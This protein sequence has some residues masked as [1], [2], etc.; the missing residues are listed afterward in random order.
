MKDAI[1]RIVVRKLEMKKLIYKSLLRELPPSDHPLL[2]WKQANLPKRAS[3]VQ[4]RNRCLLTRRS[5][6]VYRQFRLSRMCIRE[7]ANSG[8]LPGVSKSSW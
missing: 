2:I 1:T 7:L 4:V 6:G 5:R 3:R 8:V